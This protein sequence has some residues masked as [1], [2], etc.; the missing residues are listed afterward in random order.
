MS[1]WSPN[2]VNDKYDDPLNS[3]I[4][5]NSFD[6]HFLPGPNDDLSHST[7]EHSSEN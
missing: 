3:G 4:V 1:D 2:G 5:S 7:D 6:K